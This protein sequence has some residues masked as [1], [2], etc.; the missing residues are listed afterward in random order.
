MAPALTVTTACDGQGVEIGRDVARDIG[1]AVDAAD[2]TGGEDL[3]SRRRRE[4]DGCADGRRPE[5]PALGDGDG[6]VALGCLARRTEDAVVLT[7]VEPD[8]GDTV[9]NRRDRRDC[10]TRSNRRDASLQCVGV[11]RRRQAEVG[12]DRRFEGDHR[13]PGFD[14]GAHFVGDLW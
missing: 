12:E 14:G 1:T 6:Q 2:A 8:P 3:H 9:E 13:V 10:T 5:V 4:G 7:R 11:G